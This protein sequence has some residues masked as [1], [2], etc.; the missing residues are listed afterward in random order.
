VRGAG[1]RVREDGDAAELELA[2]SSEDEMRDLTKV[3]DEDV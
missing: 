1:V 2:E 3:R